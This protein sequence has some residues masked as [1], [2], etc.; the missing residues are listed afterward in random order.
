MLEVLYDKATNEVRGWCADPTQFGNFPAGKGKAVVILD[1]NT[2]T[3]ESDVYT[4]T[5]W[6]LLFTY[7]A[8]Q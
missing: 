5:L 8:N 6:G 4:I 3:I 7:T 1:C 2:P